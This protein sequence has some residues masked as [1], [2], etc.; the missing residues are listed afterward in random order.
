MTYLANKIIEAKK[1]FSK[2]EKGFFISLKIGVILF[3][4][5]GIVRLIIVNRGRCE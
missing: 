5:L 2:I 4:G 1:P 3:S